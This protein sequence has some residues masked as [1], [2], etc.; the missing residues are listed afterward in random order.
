MRITGGRLRG[1]HLA[2]F[3]GLRIRPTLDPVREAV[4]N[5]LGQDLS[6]FVVWDLFAGTG[7]LGLEALSRGAS[8]AVFVDNSPAALRLIRRNL[9]ICGCEASALVL[10]WDLRKGLPYRQMATGRAL[11]LAFFDPPYDVGL[12]PP[13]LEEMAWRIPM[14]AGCRVVVET[15]KGE[16]LPETYGRLIKVDMRIYGDT[17]VTFYEYKTQDGVQDS[18]IPGD[19]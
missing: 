5:I 3:K 15:R 1:R 9:A 2:P 6:G 13:L 11:E 17:R 4:F 12:V 8:E 10:R 19:L 7:S 14:A 18:D 16:G